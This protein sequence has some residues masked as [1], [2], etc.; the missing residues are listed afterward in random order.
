MGSI[1]WVG[2][3]KMQICNWLEASEGRSRVAHGGILLICCLPLDVLCRSLTQ[4]HCRSPLAPPRSTMVIRNY[5]F[6]FV[7]VSPWENEREGEMRETKKVLGIG[8]WFHIVVLLGVVG[9]CVWKIRKCKNSKENKRKWGFFKKK[10]FFIFFLL[11]NL[12]K[13]FLSDM[14][15]F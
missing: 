3:P 8:I 1:R 13:I 10:K 15:F 4:S 5:R 12:F 6:R 14:D 9:Y 7:C 2:A 11:I